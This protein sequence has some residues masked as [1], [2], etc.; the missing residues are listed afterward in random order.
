MEDKHKQNIKYKFENFIDNN[1]RPYITI[2]NK[3]L[4]HPFTN[5]NLIKKYTTYLIDFIEL[6]LKLNKLSNEKED[7]QKKEELYKDFLANKSHR[8]FSDI[9]I[10]EKD[11][12]VGV[13]KLDEDMRNGTNKKI[14]DI[15]F[16]RLYNIFFLCLKESLKDINFKN[17]IDD[18][19]F[20]N[21]LSDTIKNILFAY[22][23]K[24]YTKSDHV[25][26]NIIN[27]INDI[28]GD[29][30]IC[31]KSDKIRYELK[32]Y[33]Y[34]LIGR[35]IDYHPKQKDGSRITIFHTRNIETSVPDDICKY[36]SCPKQFKLENKKGQK[37]GSIYYHKYLKYKTKYLALKNLDNL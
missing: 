3:T 7:I 32:N 31:I 1:I 9:N 14:V 23:Y 10:I 28:F 19:D 30:Y 21:I 5:K 25:I 27:N 35:A 36:I 16:I 37:G 29:N 11:Y 8:D 4:D 22:T 13:L 34:L 12:N 26:N 15:Y 20:I 6:I 17:F 33:K 2:N 24:K 18:E